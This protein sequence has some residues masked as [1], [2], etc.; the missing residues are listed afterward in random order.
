MN[1]YSHI[2]SFV[3][4]VAGCAL[5]RA[6]QKPIVL[7]T[8]QESSKNRVGSP[9]VSFESTEVGSFDQLKTSMG[10]WVRTAGQSIVNDQHSRT[11]SRCLQLS[12]GK[13]TSVV[14]ELDESIDTSGQLSFWAER[15]TH[16][17]PFAFR[18][19]KHAGKG[20]VEV[21][22]GDLKIR[23]GQSFLSQIRVPLGDSTIKK[24]RFTVT[25]PA[26][27]GILIDDVT[28]ARR[29][30]QRIVRIEQLPCTLPALVGAKASPLLRIKIVTAGSLNP[31]SLTE[32]R[33]SPLCEQGDIHS[34]EA[35]IGESGESFTETIPFG[36][37]I[38]IENERNPKVAAI[39]G[40]HV[41]V[42]GE[43][44]LWIGCR[45]RDTANIDH[46]VGVTCEGVRLSDGKIV[47]FRASST[48][49]LGVALRMGGDDGVHT[50]RIPGFAT[51][52]RGTLVGVYDV[53][54]RGGADLPGDIDVGLSRSTDGGRTW[55]P[56]RVIM[57]MG[58][59]PNHHYDGIGDP[60][61][62]VDRV[63]GTIWVAATWSHGD[64]SWTGSGP[65]LK[66]EDTGQ[67]MVIRSDDD[68][69]TW[70][71]PINITDQIKKPRWSFLLQ[72]PG[73]GITMRDGTIVFAAQYQDPPD[74]AGKPAHRLP[75]STIIY[76]KDHGKTWKIGTGAY[77]DTTESQ[78]VEIEPGVLML[79]CRYNRKA[80]RVVMTKTDMGR[81][82]R[83]HASSE[84]SLIEPGACMASL[85][86]VGQELRGDVGGWLPFSNPDS[87]RARE[88]MMIKASRDRGLTWPEEHRL[89]LDEGKG[90][91]YSCLSM[92]DK[93]T[94]GILYEGSQAQIAFQRIP[95]SDVIGDQN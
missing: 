80:A 24:L 16:R 38:T 91:G 12:G 49:R 50:F 17:E 4:I 47:S 60:A 7:F 55:E 46:T 71:K 11:G 32:V 15:W 22:N 75:H 48:Q 69:V 90:R 89:L 21:F 86:N 40:K 78:V 67:L 39:S 53:R 14:L 3:A 27:T 58:D 87:T 33:L 52:N 74:V 68:G 56:M 34:F 20:W 73:K 19:E 95:L 36:Q 44:D 28:I 5:A 84:H 45:L 18:V 70:S 30:P 13:K 31:V 82:W 92:I 10:L 64:R 41:L 29:R 61:I 81:T 66:P 25:S 85:I 42:D 35:S 2:I 83:K 93:E 26:A 8:D 57:D 59:D 88:R 23:V 1:W 62:L 94:I 51:T 54:R 77:D 9:L 65:G 79:N 63:T 37:P 43:N 76:S 72:G 6:D